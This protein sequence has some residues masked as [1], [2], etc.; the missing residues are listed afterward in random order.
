MQQYAG[1]LGSSKGTS[2]C[3]TAT[4]KTRAGQLRLLDSDGGGVVELEEF[5][6]GC[7]RFS[8]E[9]AMLRFQQ[10][11]SAVLFVIGFLS[12]GIHGGRYLGNVWEAQGALGSSGEY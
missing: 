3:N 8:G 10:Y 11:F 12:E 2:H 5:F 6:L 1:S 4:A 9:A 7:L